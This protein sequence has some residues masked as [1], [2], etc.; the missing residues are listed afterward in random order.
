MKASLSSH[1][2]ALTLKLPLRAFKECEIIMI[3]EDG[4]LVGNKGEV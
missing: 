3:G 1:G 4:R 2:I